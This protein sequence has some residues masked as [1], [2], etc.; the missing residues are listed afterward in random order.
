VPANDKIFDV[1][2]Y[3][4]FLH[5]RI[6]IEGR[7]NNFGTQFSIVRSGN[8][9]TLKSDKQLFPKRYVNFLTK[10]FLKKN[11]LRDWIRV[12]ACNKRMYELKYFNIASPEEDEEDDEDDE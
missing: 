8:K 6:K 11:T 5:D 4:K 12:N 3:E 2:A 9:V 10:K 1:A 7:T